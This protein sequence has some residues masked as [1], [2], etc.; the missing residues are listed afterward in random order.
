VCNRQQKCEYYPPDRSLHKRWDVW[1]WIPPGKFKM[2]GPGEGGGTQELPVHDVIFAYGFLIG[3]YEVTAGQYKKCQIYNGFKCSEASTDGWDA[4]QW[5][6]NTL[7]GREDHPANGLSWQQAWNYC[8]WA[9]PGGRLPSESEWE[10]A[11]TGPTH[12]K[13]PWGGESTLPTCADGFAV[14]D[15]SAPFNTKPWACDPCTGPA[16]SGTRPVGS[17]LAGVAWSGALDMSGNL[18][19][20]VQDTFKTD[21]VGV[22]DDGSPWIENPS[23]TERIIRGG[24]FGSDN[25]GIRVAS[26]GLAKPDLQLGFIGVRCVW[27]PGE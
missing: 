13:Y 14:F 2:G 8:E 20:W 25:S 18:Y 19:E 16:C 26:R 3:K 1:I 6:T 15:D 21:Y 10:Y 24:Y 11:A 17:M 22:P 7:K 9:A 4:D 23:N 27:L 5:G 12:R